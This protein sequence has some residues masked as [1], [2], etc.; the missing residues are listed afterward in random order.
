MSPSL[1]NDISPKTLLVLFASTKLRMAIEVPLYLNVK[2]HGELPRV[3]RRG[4]AL[5]LARASPKL[6]VPA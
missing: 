3:L 5:G 1:P 6:R 4:G 2:N